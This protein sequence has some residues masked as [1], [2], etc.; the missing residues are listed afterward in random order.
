MIGSII[1]G[2]ILDKTKRFEETAKVCFSLSA[3]GG[4]LV[5]IVQLYNNDK[6][7]LYYLLLFAFAWIG[8]FGVPL[9][10]VCME[11]SVECVYPIPEATSTGI[12]FMGGQIVG[13]LMILLYPATATRVDPNSY[14]YLYVQT[15][16]STNGTSWNSTTTTTA[17]PSSSSLAVLDFR[18]QMYFQAVVQ[19][20]ITIVFVIFFKCAYL[21]LRSEREKL[22]EKILNSA[23][24]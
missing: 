21:R 14:E 4:I 22:A 7:T 16:Q 17:A 13:I 3:L 18:Y 23:R 10:P 24:I 9:L 1:A 11:M 5:S 2:I 15:C 20:A 12:L 19:V 8:F 6:S